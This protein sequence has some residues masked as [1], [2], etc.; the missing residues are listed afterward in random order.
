MN[1][2]GGRFTIKFNHLISIFQVS[3]KPRYLHQIYSQLINTNK[4]FE[5]L[6]FDTWYLYPHPSCWNSTL[7][8]NMLICN[9]WWVKCWSISIFQSALYPSQSANQ[10]ISKSAFYPC[11][12]F[13]LFGWIQV[14]NPG[15]PS[16]TSQGSTIL[17]WGQLS[18]DFGGQSFVGSIVC[19]NHLI[20][21]M[22]YWKYTHYKTHD[23]FEG[24][25]VHCSCNSNLFR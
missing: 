15:N 1:P 20:K 6:I 23:C 22:K 24:T 19:T 21:N 10:R 3:F 2:L 25:A 5:T 7:L 16:K 17:L 11:P 9:W 18:H 8:I 12:A 13:W 4:I 14:I